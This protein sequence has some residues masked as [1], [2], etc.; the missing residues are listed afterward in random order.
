MTRWRKSRAGAEAGFTLVEMVLVVGL[1]AFIFAGLAAVL[2]SSLRTLTI[3]KARTQGNEVATQGIEDLQRFSYS[4][5]GL[6]AAQPTPPAG[7]TLWVKLG[8]C[9]GTATAAYGEYPCPGGPAIPSPSGSYTCNRINITFAVTRYI[10]WVDPGQTSKRL[11]VFVTWRDR[12][13]LHTVSQ[14]SSVRA[15]DINSAIG[16]SPPTLTLP[17]VTASPTSPVQ[18]LLGALTGTL[19]L[20]VNADGLCGSTITASCPTPDNVYVQ[21]TTLD[22]QGDP[23]TS[24][25]SLT[26]SAGTS[27]AG[28]L[29]S[30][31]GL[32]GEGSQIF[33]FIAVRQSD[34]KG[35][36]IVVVPAT[37][38]CTSL[39]PYCG[40][41]TLPAFTGTSVP[42][43]AS[44]TPA[45]ALVADIRV[46]A[47]LTNFTTE[48]AVTVG[49]QTLNGFISVVLTL[50][51]ST[52]CT[53]TSCTF[54]GTISKS[55]GYAFASGSRPLYFT[56]TQVKGG[57]YPVDQG[58][59]AAIASG[60]VN[61]S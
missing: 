8:G 54:K 15:P 53:T 34:G 32:F 2:A 17:S 57:T 12:V 4:Q 59:I 16:L 19:S 31:D 11:A 7:L 10:A 5:L 41:A 60:P 50:D 42:T 25:K 35:N 33:T 28:S 48:D 43:S 39:D 58:Y 44:I 37:K 61:F 38:I 13:G 40:A 46:S 1:S 49:F 22:A 56:A 20:S 14:Q 27:W 6:C 47:T 55:A 51:T 21:F 52:T 23:T 18:E 9:P 3:T 29:T 24:T 26:S 30:S 36:A 45:G